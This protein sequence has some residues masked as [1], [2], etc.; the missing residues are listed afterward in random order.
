MSGLNKYSL[1]NSRQAGPFTNQNRIIDFSVP[2]GVYDLSQCFVQLVT[3]ILPSSSQVHNFVLRNTTTTLTPKNVDMIRN[4]WMSGEKVGKL[5][6]ITRVNVLQ[7]NLLELMKST[8]E[9]MSLVDSIY[10]VRDFQEGTLLSPWVEWHKEG[11]VASSYRDAYLR[12]PLNQLFSLGNTVLDVSKTGPLTVHIELE[13]LSY[14][15]FVEA[16]M[17]HSPA[18]LNE[19]KMDSVTAAT[20][21]ITTFTGT[22]KIIYDSVES[23]PYFVGQK[24]NL[25]WTAGPVVCPTNGVDIIVNGIALNINKSIT[26][27]TS[28]DFL[29]PTTPAYTG[30]AVTEVVEGSATL[31]VANANLGV[32]EVVNGKMAGDVLEYM[33]WSVEQYSNNANELQKIF[34]VEANAVNAFLMFNKNTSNLI[35]HN[36]KVSEYRMRIDNSDVYDRNIKVNYNDETG[37][38]LCHDPLHYDALNRTM[39]NASLPLKNLTCLNML[40]DNAEK[41]VTL[42]DRFR[43]GSIVGGIDLRELSLL[44]LCTPLPLTAG[45]KKVQFSVSTKAAE[46]KVENVILFK[47]IVKQVKL[48]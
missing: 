33:T 6:D 27:T 43:G 41:S 48:M 17:F 8:S 2:E 42:A 45:S 35:S 9:K 30:V 28:Y 46:D 19:G 32:C 25:K 5:E 18:L 10:Q 29:F 36:P 22:G 23:S 40:R 15:E 14:L 24:L 13:N 21:Q 34:E 44:M 47:Q 1:L 3:R 26:L 16:N 37:K 7:S 11:S 12:I 38:V 39:L 20:S 4:C 31:S